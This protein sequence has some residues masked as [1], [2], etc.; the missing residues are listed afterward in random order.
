MY[1]RPR[2]AS[3]EYLSSVTKS[4][5]HQL[6]AEYDKTGVIPNLF[7]NK[8]Q[9]GEVMSYCLRFGDSYQRLTTNAVIYEC[10]HQKYLFESTTFFATEEA[11]LDIPG[12]SGMP[13]FTLLSVP[14]DN[15]YQLQL[16]IETDNIHEALRL[17][18]E[19][20]IEH[21]DSIIMHVSTG[22]TYH[23]V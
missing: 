23:E 15:G 4:A 6:I 8:H 10:G 20:Y 18:L 13:L 1:T 14:T 21:W 17:S 2:D 16:P 19:H 5:F 12:A 11:T 3:S 22:K 9:D 7:Y